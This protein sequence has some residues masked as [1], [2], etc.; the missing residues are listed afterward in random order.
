MRAVSRGERVRSAPWIDARLVEH[1]VGDPV[2]DASRES[3]IEQ[4]GLDRRRARMQQLVKRP[5][6]GSS[7]SASKPSRLIGGSLRGS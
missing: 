5:R 4:H 7:W 1:L 2:A 3:L 6:D